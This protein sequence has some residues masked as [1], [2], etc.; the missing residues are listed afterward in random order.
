VAGPPD[1]KETDMRKLVVTEFVSLD[2]VME[3]PGGSEKT[4]HG[5]WT[6]PYWSDEMGEFKLAELEASDTLLLGRVTYEGFAAAW[7]GRTDDGGFADRMNNY[8]KYVVSST[9]KTASWQN[10]TILGDDL[11]REITR[12]KEE[13]GKDIL[14]HG[15]ATL[16]QA[17]LRDQLV[18]ELHLETYPIVL[19]TGKRLFADDSYAKLDL[20]SHSVTSKGVLLLSYRRA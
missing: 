16:V 18:D 4:A 8:R 6:G 5:G 20:A 17:L 3:D 11:V 1:G 14:V 9:M 15:S 7:P 19:G 13:P 12:I 10:S 2:G